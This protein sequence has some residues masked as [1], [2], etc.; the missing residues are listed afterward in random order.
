MNDARRKVIGEA[1]AALNTALALIEQCA[2]EEREY[3][4]NM[5]ENMQN[6]E[7]G[8]AASNAAGALEEARDNT[9]NT[10]DELGNLE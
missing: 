1:V 5:P 9:Q 2:E 6:G 7:K 10:I 3:Y 4:D 8:E